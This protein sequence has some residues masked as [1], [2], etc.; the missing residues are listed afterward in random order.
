MF[1]GSAL[2]NYC[3]KRNCNNYMLSKHIY[4]QEGDFTVCAT[5][6]VKH[7]SFVPTIAIST[8]IHIYCFYC[9]K[10]FISYETFDIY[11]FRMIWVQIVSVYSQCIK[12][13]TVNPNLV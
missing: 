11:D 5:S 2:N 3:W 1:F 4:H 6:G 12:L 13:H 7:W 8:T 10:K 9:N